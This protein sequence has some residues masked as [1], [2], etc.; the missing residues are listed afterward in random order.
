ML[1]LGALKIVFQ[2]PQPGADL[3]PAQ[4]TACSVLKRGLHNTK[5]WLNFSDRVEGESIET[6]PL[7]LASR[8]IFGCHS[9]DY[10][11]F[12]RGERRFFCPTDVLFANPL[13]SF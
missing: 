12:D 5:C 10:I 7:S 8:F 11:R 6:A 4:I 13:G 3:E 1:R 2:Q 9:V